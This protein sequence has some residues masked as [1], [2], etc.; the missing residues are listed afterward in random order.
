MT[1]KIKEGERLNT[2]VGQGTVLKGECSVNGTVRVDGVIDGS[3]KAT[4][5]AILG[6]SGQIKGDLL[7][8]NAIVGGIV[9]G[10]VIA[11]GRLEL[12]SGARVEG[13]IKAKKLVVE[14]GVFFQGFCNMEQKADGKG[15][16]PQR[17]AQVA[18]DSKKQ[19]APSGTR[20]KPEE[21]GKDDDSDEITFHGEP[22]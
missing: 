4:G 15:K 8:G 7:V 22:I 10:S 2:I 5:V 16:R 18:A 11:E 19:Q 14:E 20:A 6:K 9:E 17:V 3:L 1:E 13:D 12:Q 21:A